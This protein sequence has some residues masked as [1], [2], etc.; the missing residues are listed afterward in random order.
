[1]V[2]VPS[3]V[4]GSQWDR[5]LS[6]EVWDWD[7]TSR[8]D[9]MGALSFGVSEIFRRPISGWFKLLAQDEGEYYNIPVPDP[10]LQV[11][12]ATGGGRSRPGLLLP[13]PHLSLTSPQEPQPDVTTASLPQ[14]MPVPLSEPFPAAALTQTAVPSCPPVHVSVP[15]KVK[16]G[17]HD[18]NFLM[19]LGKGSFGK[20]RLSCDIKPGASTSNRSI[21]LIS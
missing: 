2:S 10:D 6:V 21:I 20:V 9:F 5:R 19:V 3:S 14:A 18:F 1:M 8:N 13:C 16:M 11:G 4:R 7:R 15:A 17:I 12:P